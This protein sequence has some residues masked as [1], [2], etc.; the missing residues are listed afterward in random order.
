MVMKMALKKK[1]SIESYMDM[2]KKE[3]LKHLQ[4][5]MTKEIFEAFSKAR[6]SRDLSAQE[7]LLASIKMFIAETKEL[8]SEIKKSS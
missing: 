5:A 2:S 7:I 3:D 4:V 6:K 1:L 8:N